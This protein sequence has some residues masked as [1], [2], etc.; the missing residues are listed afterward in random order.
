[1]PRKVKRQDEHMLDDAVINAFRMTT[2]DE[3]KK[4]ALDWCLSDYAAAAEYARRDLL[5]IAVVVAAL[6]DIDHPLLCSP[7]RGVMFCMLECALKVFAVEIH[8][9]IVE[10]P[11]FYKVPEKLSTGGVCTSTDNMAL[12]HIST[13][14]TREDGTMY[15][16]DG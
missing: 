12:V 3:R 15:T 2:R 4:V 10:I 16:V 13:G 8:Q 11:M 7:G 14:E 5:P 6:I 9:V 1:M